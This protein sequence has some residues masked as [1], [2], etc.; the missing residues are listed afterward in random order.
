MDPPATV[1]VAL[2]DEGTSAWRPVAAECVGPGL[3]RLAGPV[4]ECNS[5]RL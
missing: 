3:Y 5:R 4:P 1:Y 2:R